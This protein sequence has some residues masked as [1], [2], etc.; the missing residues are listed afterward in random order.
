MDFHPPLCRTSVAIYP[1]QM[2]VAKMLVQ[3]SRYRGLGPGLRNLGLPALCRTDD[4]L[5]LECTDL[6][7][8]ESLD[9]DVDVDALADQTFGTCIDDEPPHPKRRRG[10]RR[11]SR[12]VLAPPRW[13]G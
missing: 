4:W 8:D 5:A 12:A 7:L 1:N 9:L 2:E 3:N 11:L 6:G 10:A 13:R